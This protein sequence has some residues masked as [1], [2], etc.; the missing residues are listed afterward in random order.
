MNPHGNGKPEEKDPEA[1]LRLLELE[2]AQRRA[3][4]K[5]AGAPYRGFRAASFI[6]L[7]IVIAGVLFA[8]YY[9]FLA[10]GLEDARARA[11]HPSATPAAQA[12]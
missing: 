6:F 11:A 7:F 3:Q 4:R 12:P 10:G 9:I 1:A 8:V 2:L 5:Q